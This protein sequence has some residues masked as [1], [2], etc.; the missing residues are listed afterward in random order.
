LRFG[1]RIE[2]AIAGD[3]V[4]LVALSGLITPEFVE[5]A[6]RSEEVSAKRRRKLPP[7]LVTWLVVAMALFRTLA[8]E[9]VLR[10][11]LDGLEGFRRFGF[12]E[13]PCATSIAHAR[14]RL[15]W[16]PVRAL[17]ESLVSAVL[18]N[19]VEACSWHGLQVFTLDGLCCRMPDTDANESHFGRPG[20]TRGGKA[21]FPQLRSLLLVTAWTHVVARAVVGPFAEGELTLA[22]RLL[23][24]IQA[25]WLLL[26]DRNFYAY[27]WLAGLVSRGQPFVVR[28]KTDRNALGVRKGAR[29][30]RGDRLASVLI[31]RGLGQKRRDLP[32][33]LVLRFVTATR[34]GFRRRLLT[35]SLL[36]AK[37]F[38]AGEIAA[39][40]GDRWEAELA[41]REIKIHQADK[42]VNVTFR[43]HTPTRV[44][45]EFYALLVAYN[46][47]R[48]LMADA[49]ELVGVKPIKLSFTDCLERIRAALARGSGEGLQ[50]LLLV[51]LSL[52]RLQPRRPGRR[53]ERAVKTKMSNYPRT[54]RRRG[55]HRTCAWK[56]VPR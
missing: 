37:A 31:P 29:L 3:R 56:Q 19:H 11:V 23:P 42:R 51:D 4:S 7:E 34:R 35:T 33:E 41:Y 55:T 47:I 27:A 10:R 25:S 20:T 26:M 15:G 43:S 46:C 38:P 9:N 6:L 45:Q 32:R 5:R 40:Y 14:D 17:F 13:L 30:G 12:A 53:Y 8:I 54:R 1:S 21:G 52:C 39:L 48:A 22:E 28:A 36:D 24:A 49:A 44:L 16:K 2:R 18:P 50:Q